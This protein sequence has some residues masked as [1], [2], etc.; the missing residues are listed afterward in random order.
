M[1]KLDSQLKMQHL[2]LNQSGQQLFQLLNTVP[3]ETL[4][5]IDYQKIIR[6]TLTLPRNEK[7]HLDKESPIPASLSIMKTPESATPANTKGSSQTPSRSVASLKLP[8]R[9]QYGRRRVPL[10]KLKER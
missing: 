5:Y 7:L 8:K 3:T 10:Q 9:S 2:L 4:R 6:V 1:N